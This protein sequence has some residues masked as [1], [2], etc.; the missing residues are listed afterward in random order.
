VS[1]W[2]LDESK[3]PKRKPTKVDESLENTIVE[4]RKKLMA[5]STPETRYSYIGAVAIHQEL[6]KAAYIQ[7]PALT[8]INRIIKRN[9]Y[10]IVLSLYL[11]RSTGVG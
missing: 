11:P 8:T 3:A 9:S 4:I 2:Y 10:G 7:K 6:D 1:D 5:H